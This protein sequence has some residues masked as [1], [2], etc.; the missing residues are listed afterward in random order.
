MATTEMLCFKV[1]TKGDLYRVWIYTQ[2]WSYKRRF[3]NP[4][5]DLESEIQCEF[6]SES[7]KIAI[8]YFISLAE[9]IYILI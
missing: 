7:F 6:E 3:V 5:G 2:I 8:F 9:K 1:Y 4:V